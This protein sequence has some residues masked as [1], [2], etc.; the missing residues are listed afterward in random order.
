M[1][2]CSEGEVQMPVKFISK[3]K[4]KMQFSL[5][6][7]AFISEVVELSSVESKKDQC[8]D[9]DLRRERRFRITTVSRSDLY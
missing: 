6:T 1:S 2:T 3:R 9:R 5:H 4:R 7:L 8:Q